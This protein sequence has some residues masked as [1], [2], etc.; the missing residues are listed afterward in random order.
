MEGGKVGGGWWNAHLLQVVVKVAFIL[1]QSLLLKRRKV[2]EEGWWN[3]VE[4]EGGRE[5]GREQTVVEA[6]G[7]IPIY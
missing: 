7:E 1:A 2:R 5:G 6:G 4:M 3:L